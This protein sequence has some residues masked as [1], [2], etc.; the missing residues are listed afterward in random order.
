MVLWVGVDDTDSLLGMCT[1]FLATEFVRELTR[2]LDLIGYPRLVRLNPN[3]TWKTR[4]NGAVC[5]RFGRGR[6]EPRIIGEIDG[7]PVRAYPS[8]ETASSPEAV[9]ERAAEVLEKWAVFDDP[10]TNPGLVVLEHR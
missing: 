3:I 10:T 5:I 6:G 8:G 4:G 7:A 2:D 1:T 9:L